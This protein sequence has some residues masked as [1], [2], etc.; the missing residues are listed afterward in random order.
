MA[1]LYMT[2][3]RKAIAPNESIVLTCTR[4]DSVFHTMR[5]I[6]HFLDDWKQ[7]HPDTSVMLS[8]DPDTAKIV[9]SYFYDMSESEYAAFAVKEGEVLKY[10]I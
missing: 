10:G 6:Y 9:N 4:Q 8:V 2:V 3:G 1:Y 5:K 7:S